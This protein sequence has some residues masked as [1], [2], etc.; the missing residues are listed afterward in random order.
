MHTLLDFDGNLSA[1]INITNGKTAD[2]KGVYD[3]PLLKGSVIVADRFYK[4]LSLLNVWD[5]NGV[6]FVIRHKENIQYTV[7]KENRLPENRHGCRTN[8]TIWQIWV[9][10]VQ[11]H[12]VEMDEIRV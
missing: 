7:I 3:I 6:Y 1:Y 8:C 11:W 2:N 12:Q 10:I 4:D 9:E 5:S